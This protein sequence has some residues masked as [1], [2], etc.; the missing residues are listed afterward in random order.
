[1]QISRNDW[2][3]Y[4]A[5]LSAIDRKAADRMQ[6]WMERS[7][8]AEPQD[9]VRM[10]YAIS[11]KYG[12]AASA[13]ACE[14]YDATAAAQGVSLPPAVPAPTATYPE[15]AKAVRGTIKNQ[16]S[17]VPATVGRLVRQAGADTTLHN[18][19]RDGAEWAWVPNG[20]TCAFCV[21]LASNGWQRQGKKA[22]RGEH[23]EHI[24]ANCDCTYAVRFDGKSTVEGYGN[25]ERY[26]ETYSSADGRSWRDKLN[27]MRREQYAADHSGDD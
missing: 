21:M 5:R 10:A 26:L 15:T 17:T 8:D 19:Q 9:L 11:T 22:A 3:K 25:G 18:A 4:I 2:L 23:A 20:D 14:M 27:S 13:L 1:M 16:R 6:V 7:P 12:E 24:H